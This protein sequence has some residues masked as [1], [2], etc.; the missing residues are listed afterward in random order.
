MV[1]NLSF[2]ANRHPTED[3]P[4]LVATGE[5]HTFCIQQIYSTSN[6]PSFHEDARPFIGLPRYLLRQV[7]ASVAGDA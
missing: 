2:E 6:N 4:H 1:D 7:E 3:E 5:R